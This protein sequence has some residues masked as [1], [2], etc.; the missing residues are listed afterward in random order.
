MSH[1]GLQGSITHAND[2]PQS[3]FQGCLCLICRQVGHIVESCPQLKGSSPDI[4]TPRPTP[5]FEPASTKHSGTAL[6]DRCKQ[7]NALGQ[8]PEPSPLRDR[9]PRSPEKG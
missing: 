6:C 9:G 8:D 4:T 1:S 3:S 5:P 7:M 2:P